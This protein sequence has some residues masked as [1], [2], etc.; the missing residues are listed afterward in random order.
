MRL[1]CNSSGTILYVASDGDGT[2]GM[3]LWKGVYTSSWAWTQI[4]ISATLATNTVTYFGCIAC[5]K[6][7]Q[8]VYLSITNLP[9]WKSSNYGVTW[10]EISGSPTINYS[11]NAGVT[12]SDNGSIVM[13]FQYTVHVSSDYGVTWNTNAPDLGALCGV[14]RTTKLVVGHDSTGI[15]VSTDG[16]TTWTLK[17]GANAYIIGWRGLTMSLDGQIIAGA[18]NAQIIVS[19]DSGDTWYTH[20]YG[21]SWDTIRVSADLTKLIV[22]SG[23]IFF[24]IDS[25]VTWK[26]LLNAGYTT[27]TSIWVSADFT[28]MA[29]TTN[30]GSIYYSTDSGA[31]WTDGAFSGSRF[32]TGITGDSTGQYLKAVENGGYIWLSRDYGASWYHYESLA[33][34][35]FSAGAPFKSIA[36]S[37]VPLHTFSRRLLIRACGGGIVL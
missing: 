21:G 8:Y 9:I 35:S 24:S 20:S 6:N 34:Y 28:K 17:P 27:W 26:L 36:V 10:A 29:A 22:M 25:G 3:Y 23:I 5:S 15:Y 18:G 13:V 16:G 32:W 4:L 19:K 37:P 11:G 12:C 30:G 33:P 2:T 7:G 31:T 1:A 14:V